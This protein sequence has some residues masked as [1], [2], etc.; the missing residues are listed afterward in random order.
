[1]GGAVLTSDADQTNNYCGFPLDP[2]ERMPARRKGGTGRPVTP[3]ADWPELR[4]LHV[5]KTQASSNKFT[6]PDFPNFP[7]SS[8]ELSTK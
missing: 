7:L 1:M 5:A 6:S 3:V 8:D 4:Y 2:A